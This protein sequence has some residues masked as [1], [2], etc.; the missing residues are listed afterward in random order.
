MAGTGKDT[1][2]VHLVTDRFSLGGGIEHIFQVCNGLPGIKFHVFGEPGPAVEKFNGLTNVTIHDDGF[3]PAKIMGGSPDIVHIHHL[4]PVDTLFRHSLKKNTYGIPVLFTAHGLHIHKF[5]FYGTLSARIKYFLRFHL[6][7]R[8]LRRVNRII[9]VSKEDKEFLEQRYRLNHVTY[10]TNGIDFSRVQQAAGLD[11]KELR[12]KLDLPGTDFLFATAARFNFQK[13]YDIFFRALSLIKGTLNKNPCRFILAGDG[14]EFDAMKRLSRELGVDKYVMFLGART[15]IYHILSACDVFL[16]PSR[17]EGLPI[18]LLETGLLK[19]P[20]I[21]SDT[22]GNSEII[23]PD[24]GLLFKNLDKFDLA[25]RIVEVLKGK[26]RL[27]E[28]AERLYNEV[29]ANYNLDTMLKGL[30]DLYGSFAK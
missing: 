7:K 29:H 21:A 26:H 6:E 9:A 19:L 13:G 20:V 10:L 11:K 5:E 17:W 28:Y 22:Y 16:L 12:R 2:R 27:E 1:L 14:E 24:R 18:T 15:D 23:K 30:N 3:T 25:L 4:R 8:L